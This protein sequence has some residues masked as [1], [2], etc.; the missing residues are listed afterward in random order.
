MRVVALGASRRGHD[1]V[2]YLA[3]VAGSTVDTRLSVPGMRAAQVGTSL[4]RDQRPL[5]VH[6]GGTVVPVPANGFIAV[7]ID[8][9]AR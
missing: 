7:S 4:E 9:V 6:D 8:R 5:E 2:A 3:S 1:L